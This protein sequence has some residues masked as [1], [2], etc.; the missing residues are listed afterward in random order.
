[1]SHV[2]ATGAHLQVLNAKPVTLHLFMLWPYFLVKSK[3]LNFQH[4]TC[5]IPEKHL[6]WLIFYYFLDVAMPSAKILGDL[7]LIT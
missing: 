4:Y 3:S 2:L 6:Y 5:K 1:M 7:N